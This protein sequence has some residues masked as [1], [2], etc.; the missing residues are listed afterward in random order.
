MRKTKF[1]APE[2]DVTR[3]PRPFNEK[4]DMFSFG[5]LLQDFQIFAET[6]GNKIKYS[7]DFTNLLEKLTSSSPKDRPTAAQVI[8]KLLM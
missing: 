2:L 1:L 8:Q 5:I 4:V 7:D 6:I 3:A